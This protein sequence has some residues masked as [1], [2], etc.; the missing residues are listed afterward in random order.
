MTRLLIATLAAAAAFA[1]QAHAQS[2]DDVALAAFDGCLAMPSGASIAEAAARLGFT[3]SAL[4][5]DRYIKPIGTRQLQ[6]RV[7]SEPTSGGRS[8]RTCSVG[9]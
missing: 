1:S 6:I 9:V 5:P 2:L 7:A 4:A 3:P 8:M